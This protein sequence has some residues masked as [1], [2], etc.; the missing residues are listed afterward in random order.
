MPH[1]RLIDPLVEF[2]KAV[3]QRGFRY[4]RDATKPTLPSLVL[5]S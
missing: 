2:D 1:C 4:R 5:S 3:E